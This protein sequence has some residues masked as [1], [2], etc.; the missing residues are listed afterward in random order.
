MVN[1]ALLCGINNYKSQPDL[2]GCVNDVNNMLRLL[3]QNFGFEATQIRTLTNEQV[4]K[5]AI[6]TEWQWLLQD[7]QSG[8]NLVFHFSGH[9]SFVPDDGDDETDHLDEITCLYDMDFYDPATFLRDD[10]WNAMLQQ[11]P[12]GVQFT[13]VMDNCHSGTG[14]RSIEVEV[15]GRAR[16]LAVDVET[17][18]QRSQDSTVRSLTGGNSAEHLLRSALVQTR[19]AATTTL[20]SLN[21][22][23]YKQLKADP[24][25]VL[26]RF[27]VPPADLQARSVTRS[28]ASTLPATL[29]KNHLLLA[30]CQD[31][32]TAADAHIEGD[33]HG[34][35]TY[36]LCDTIRNAP[37]LDSENQIQTVNQML[38]TNQ[39]PQNPQH[40]GEN[41]PQPIFGSRDLT[42]AGTAAGTDADRVPPDS[43]PSPI[44]LP[45]PSPVQVA[46]GLDPENQRL[47][48]E[49]YLKLLDTLVG[50]TGPREGL[51]R[52]TGNRHLVYV[53]GISQHR[54][55][56]SDSWWAALKPHV[57]LLFGAGKLNETRW[58]VLWSDL[59]NAR[60][61]AAPVDQVQKE[62][63]RREIE[64]ILEERQRQAIAVETGG[65]P[66]ARQA[67]TLQARDADRGAGF[68]LDDF[69]VYM[70]DSNMRQQIIDRF[71][72]VVRPLL[73]SGN[74]ID[75]IC[76]SWG[77]VVA[78]EGLRE[79]EQDSSLSGRVS[80]LFTAGSALSLGPVRASLRE[81]NRDGRRPNNVDR[82][83]NVDAQGDL[84]GGMLGDLFTVTQEYLSQDP[85]GCTRGLFGYNLVCA[86][87]S[88]FRETNLTV[89]RDIF[90]RFLNS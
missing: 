65:G 24:T 52:Q 8:D 63:L 16:T 51:L 17:S 46:N 73:S 80:N 15:Q 38:K 34:A 66:A 87:G 59:V 43:A 28:V 32:Q 29:P 21:T 13:I 83:I 4:T 5:T 79:L 84:V 68:S 62:Q 26:P 57:G 76:H 39:F 42:A 44:P 33:F 90:A 22:Q 61:S 36:Y 55:G 35:F 1:K 54:Q 86:H 64:L 56:Y 53:H 2:R 31:S 74:R 81:A 45:I 18:A 14:T 85:T 75:I 50:A 77:T 23:E 40:E 58:E 41:R 72:K 11:V 37:Q 71:T 10:E 60:V 48:I 12:E 7:A 82:W 88:Y 25:I 49:A 67:T 20:A 27:L 70:V 30:A 6:Q 3:T 69:L 47:L 9:G 78:Y 19:D 89:N